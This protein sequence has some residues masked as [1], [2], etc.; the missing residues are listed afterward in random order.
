MP[1]IIL[2]GCT[3]EPLLNYLKA[4]GVL[5]LVSEQADPQARGFWKR[6]AFTLHSRFDDVSLLQFF[7]SDYAPTPI[8]SPWN[9]EG[10]FLSE[11]GTSVKT[12]QNFKNSSDKRFSTIRSVIDAI[13]SIPLLKEFAT[14]RDRKKTLD[15]K[16]SAKTI[17]E[18][19]KAELAMATSRVKEIKQSV[20]AGIRSNLP[21]QSLG[22]LDACMVIG[23]GGFSA[24]PSLGSGGVGGGLDFGAN[25]LTNAQLIFSD[26]RSGGWLR[27][28]LLADTGATL[29]ETSIGQFAPGRIGGPNGTQGF[30]GDSMLNPWDFVLM[31]E[32]TII[33]AGA[34]VRRFG[35]ESTGRAVFPFAVRTSS[36]GYDS[37]AKDD[38]PDSR[39]ELWLPLWSR[40]CG[41]AE[42][43]SL[44]GEGRS[45]VSGKSARDG[46]DFARAVTSLGVDRG[47]TE[48]TRFSFLQRNGK[49]FLATPG[50]R[51]RV[52]ER[53][54][55]DLLRQVDPWLD[56]FRSAC[57]RDNVPTRFT[58]AL[59]AIDFAI[60]DFCRYG[61]NAHFQSI[62]IAL[63]QAE[64]ELAHT[65]GKVGQSKITPNPLAGLSSA[66][67][68]AANDQSPEFEIA[69]ALAG[70]HDA[71]GKLGPLRANLEPVIVCRTRQGELY[72][73]WAERERSVVW[74]ATD[75]SAN[76]AAVLGRR[77]MDG[78]RKGCEELPLASH[79]TA[80]TAAIAAFLSSDLDDAK[81]EALLWGLMLIERGRAIMKDHGTAHGNRAARG[82][83]PPI[84]SL[85][86]LLFLPRPLI[87]K[88]DGRGCVKWRLVNGKEEGIRIRP[89][90]AILSLLG[91]GRVG[92]AAAIAMRRLRASGLIPL[93]HRR[94]GGPSRDAEW[95]EVTVTPCEGQRLAA[96]L[97]IPL[98]VDAVNTVLEQVTR[99]DE[100]DDDTENIPS[101]A[102]GETFP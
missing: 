42:V 77:V 7:R 27:L 45:E 60:F 70:V 66:W 67:T 48:F 69:V 90:P 97:L 16:K 18:V 30:E 33:L 57:S 87:A 37:A 84:Y 101:N 17:T 74:N 1:E 93:P 68:V 61:G 31:L 36:V 43:S 56:R 83:L 20:V 14:N 3:P 11:S 8:I 79:F 21:D 51:F 35:M 41:I 34:A 58:S 53:Q 54:N 86:K 75:P 91:T 72:A 49:A 22:W 95:S 94:S 32:G 65:C 85:L 76:L 96:T 63:G 47:V 12:I 40:P 62:I 19:E 92:E 24:A 80:S 9:G 99:A 78:A 88:R 89:E 44:F 5:R 55:T 26:R 23:T 71:A 39:G 82:A 25:F 46:V 100:F 4:L 98:D 64:R 81:I 10:G 13:E 52:E 28:S 59:R 73:Q 15:K 6:D 29:V 102:Q 2:K 38:A 50:G